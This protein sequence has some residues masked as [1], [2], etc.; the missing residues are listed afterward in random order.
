MLHQIPIV[1]ILGN[2]RKMSIL[3]GCVK[4]CF[5]YLEM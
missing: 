5:V 1:N 4:I 2:T 3:D